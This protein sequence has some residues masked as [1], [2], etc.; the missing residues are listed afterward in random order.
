MSSGADPAPHVSIVIPCR[1]EARDIEACLNSVLAQQPVEGGIE[2]LVADGCSDDG[3]LAVLDRIVG[4]DQ[5]VRV[6]DNPSRIVPTGLNRA[7]REARGSIVIRMDAH[8]RYASDYVRQ[9]IAVL[10]QTGADNVGGPAL[11]EHDG[12]YLGRSIVAAYH[13]PFSVGGARSHN[14]GYEGELDTVTY[15]CWHKATLFRIGLF[16][17][18]LVR[19][20]DDE[21]NFRLV[22]SGGRIWQSPS[23]RSW[24]RPRSSLWALFRQYRQYGYWKVRVIQKHG[25][26]AALRHLAPVAFAMGLCAG[27]AFGFLHWWF[28]VA[29]AATVGCYILLN[30]LVSAL[31]AAHDGW[32]LLPVLPAAFLTFH[33]GYGI[34][35][36]QGIFDFIVLRRGGRATMSSL[37]RSSTSTEH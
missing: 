15:G 14:S 10:Q 19:N 24:Y 5:R 3:T 32:D 6:I 31:A 34:G 28:W 33:L 36:A 30:L 37:T 4:R 29:Y 20:Q 13:S 35:F 9:C 12:S 8:T 1:N 2:I 22:R 23:I 25:Q 17:E 11:T 27:W 26:P 21:L 16:D 18:E 7:I